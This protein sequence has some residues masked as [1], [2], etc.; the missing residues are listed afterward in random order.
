MPLLPRVRPGTL[1][2][3][4]LGV[5]AV[6]PQDPLF[7][8]E[9]SLPIDTQYYLEQQLAKPL[10]RIFEPIL[11]EG[12]AEAVLLRTGAPG[13][14]GH[15]GGAGGHRPTTCLLSCRGGPHA[16]QNGAH[17]QGW[18][19]PGLRQ[20]PQLLHWLPHSAQPPG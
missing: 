16:L 11:G 6:W 12:R 7:V 5:T 2:L 15:P 17:G 8:L 14:W 1:T 18:R 4:C 13:T 19:P 9:H 3:G 10:L 20:T